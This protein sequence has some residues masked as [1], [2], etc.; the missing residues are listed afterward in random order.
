MAVACDAQS[1]LNASA[2]LCGL[3]RN[4]LL[5]IQAYT[6]CQVANLPAAQQSCI[7]CGDVNPVA[8]PACTCAIYYVRPTQAF[9]YWDGATWVEFIGP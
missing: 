6:L 1:L 9:F 5:R 7:L 2:C 4:Q 8:A 3:D